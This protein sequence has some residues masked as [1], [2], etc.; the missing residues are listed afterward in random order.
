[1][2]ALAL[3]RRTRHCVAARLMCPLDVDVTNM[4][5]WDGL[6]LSRKEGPAA[7]VLVPACQILHSA[8]AVACCGT[9]GCWPGKTLRQEAAQTCGWGKLKT[10]PA[11]RNLSPATIVDGMVRLYQAK[12]KHGC[13][14]YKS[15]A[16][17]AQAASA[18]PCCS[19]A[20][21]WHCEAAAV[22]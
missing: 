2:F 22:C 6:L 13:V 20:Q 5:M 7:A 10:L 16:K 18:R 1:M 8:A 9:N 12:F 14:T 11:M 4:T 19:H 21:R 17:H 15:H 3:G